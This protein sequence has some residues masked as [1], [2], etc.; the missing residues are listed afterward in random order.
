MPKEAP[1]LE[2]LSVASPCTVSWDT[3]KGDDRVR[4]CGS[5]RLNVYN[6][7]EMS[8]REAEALVRNRE[9]RLCVRFF[10]RA[11]GTV[12]TKDCPVG[13]R[14]IRRRIA[15]AWAA[16]AALFLGAFLGACSKTSPDGGGPVPAGGGR[17]G[18]GA[19][20]GIAAPGGI[21]TMGRPALPPLQGDVASP[22]EIKGEVFVPPKPE[23]PAK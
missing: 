10:R 6:L 15:R 19:T 5:C 20:T 1:V 7:S 17:P 14:A 22:P 21:E 13:I 3:M 23:P 8:H 16:A 4:H 11:D 12:L 18:D 9:G 2:G